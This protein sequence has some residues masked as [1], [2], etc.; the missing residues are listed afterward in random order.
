[1]DINQTF[2]KVRDE[3]NRLM[4]LNVHHIAYAKQTEG[5]TTGTDIFLTNG[6]VVK[7]NTGFHDFPAL[8]GLVDKK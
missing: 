3:N 1:M 2:I 7:I 4:Y 5:N 8:M 6:N